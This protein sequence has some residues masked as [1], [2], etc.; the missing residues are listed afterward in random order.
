MQLFLTLV[1][2]LVPVRVK[3]LA[4]WSRPISSVPTSGRQGATLVRLNDTHLLS[5]GGVGVDA[6]TNLSVYYQAE[7]Y[8][9][10]A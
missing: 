10:G 8:N 1:A 5:Y 4:S 2:A 3:A 9:M 7:A 6:V